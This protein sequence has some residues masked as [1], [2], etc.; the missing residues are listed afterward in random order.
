MRTVAGAI[1]VDL[2][3]WQIRCKL[4]WFRAV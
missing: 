4:K 3:Q 1:T 2:Y